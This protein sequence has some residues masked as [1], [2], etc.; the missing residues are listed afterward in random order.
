MTRVLLALALAVALP[1]QAFDANG[2]KLGGSEADVRKVFPNAY[3][4]ALEWKSDAA[5]RRCD[6]ARAMYA[7]ARARLTVYLKAGEVQAF[8]LRFDAR[9]LETLKQHL[10]S[11]Y[12]KPLSEATEVIP[13][14]DKG[15]RRVFKMRWEKGAERAVLTAPENSKRVGLEAWRGNFDTEIY[16]VK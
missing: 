3:C 5:D 15:E 13:R 10:R 7:A 2:M 6:D 14:G 11:A 4:K 12:G 9:D 16:R 1:A 8:D